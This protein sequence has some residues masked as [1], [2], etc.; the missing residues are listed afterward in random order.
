MNPATPREGEKAERPAERRGQQ[1]AGGPTI[2]RQPPP[3]RETVPR[4]GQALH[5]ASQPAGAPSHSGRRRNAPQRSE[6][7]EA[8]GRSRKRVDRG[9]SSG[10]T[11]RGRRA[12]RTVPRPATIQASRDSPGTRK[13]NPGR[14][15][16]RRP[17]Q[18]AGGRGG[19][20]DDRPVGA[21]VHPR[22]PWERSWVAG[23]KPPPDEGSWPEPKPCARRAQE[24]RK[25][26]AAIAD[27]ERTHGDEAG[28]A[29]VETRS[30]QASM[31][32]LWRQG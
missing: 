15:R 23:V 24:R 16:P 10:T 7:S 13:R 6:G 22:R 4:R 12:E 19:A 18:V 17:L 8:G 11:R 26:H 28:Q 5:G 9:K 30:P 20:R 21:S 1:P 27:Q 31:P 25:E 14:D 29:P 32:V 2:P 3:N